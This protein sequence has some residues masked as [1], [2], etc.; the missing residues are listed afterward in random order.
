MAGTDAVDETAKTMNVALIPP[1][2]RSISATSASCSADWLPRKTPTS[3][4][5]PQL[6]NST[7]FS[8]SQRDFSGSALRTQRGLR[9]QPIV[10]VGTQAPCCDSRRKTCCRKIHGRK[11]NRRKIS[12]RVLYFSA[13]HF[14]ARPDFTHHTPE[15]L[16]EKTRIQLLVVQKVSSMTPWQ[17]R[18]TSLIRRMAEDMLLRN[19]S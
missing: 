19:R 13:H 15:N 4:T 5:A 17:N 12:I 14:F 3:V 18:Q 11:M 16:R 6:Q 8:K 7:K 9:P 1:K 2:S 10:E